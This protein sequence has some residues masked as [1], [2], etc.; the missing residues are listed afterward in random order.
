MRV[1][2]GYHDATLFI[3]FNRFHE[4]YRRKLRE[5]LAP[6]IKWVQSDGFWEE[7]FKFSSIDKLIAAFGSELDYTPGLN[8]FLNRESTGTQLDRMLALI[9]TLQKTVKELRDEVVMLKD[10]QEGSN[11][12]S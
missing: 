11:A 3:K 6:D 1:I 2:V 7:P 5:I 8:A 12:E 9:D 4:D 10:R